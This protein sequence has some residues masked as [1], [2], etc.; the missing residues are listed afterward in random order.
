MK[1]AWQ[2]VASGLLLAAAM[3]LAGCTRSSASATPHIQLVPGHDVSAPAFIR[4]TGLTAAEEQSFARAPMTSEEWHRLLVVSVKSHDGVK[5]AV[6]MAGKYS[7]EN[8]AL[9]FTP[10]FPFDAGRDY[11]VRFRDTVATVSLP[12]PP[13]SART[14]VTRIYPGGDVLPENQLR[15]YIEFSAPMGRRGGVDHVRL[16]DEAGREVEMP[17]L[18]LDAEFWNTERTRYTVFF[19]PGRQ[20]RGILPNRELG[21]SL[22]EGRAYTLVVDRSWT[23]GNGQSL[24]E[25]FTRRFRVGPPELS[26]LDPARWRITPPRQGTREPLTV[27]FPKPLDHGLL[28]SAIGVRRA[29][30]SLTGDVRVEQQETRWTMT[31]VEPWTAGAYELFV[32]P[33]LEDL[34]GNRIGRA[35]E[36]DGFARPAESPQESASVL[37]FTIAP[38]TR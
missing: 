10:L 14:Y 7:I 11:E 2:T 25:S 3:L 12:A 19:D 36:V 27:T 37:S 5:P 1:G 17:F 32:L 35:F 20:K 28:M 23:D 24:R 16:F 34:A 22:V 26:P 38:D 8:G 18:P 30:Q 21:P 31:P 15:M 33:I 6:P 4:V 13:P 9:R 29:G